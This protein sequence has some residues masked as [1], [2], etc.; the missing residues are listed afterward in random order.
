[1]NIKDVLDQMGK[2]VLSD[3]SKTMLSES[4]TEA[5]EKSVEDKVK[6]AVE[7]ALV[8]QDVLHAEKLENL[9]ERVDED[10]SSKLKMVLEKID[11]DHKG[12]LINIVEHYKGVIS[13]DAKEFKDKL[14]KNMSLFMETYLDD[15]IPADVI[16][17]AVENTKA[18]RIL[19]QVKELVAINDDYVT[20]VVQEAIQDGKATID[21]LKSE[22]GEIIKENMKLTQDKKFVEA[23]L[24]LENKSSNF[25]N[26]KQ[27]F[28][29]KTLKG[30]DLDYIEENFDYV[31]N[32]YDK[33][34]DEDVEEEKN[35][36]SSK[37][38]TEKIDTPSKVIEEGVDSDDS[39]GS[40]LEFMQKQDKN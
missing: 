35:N 16:Q 37:I 27:D 25:S 14:V 38:I 8:D 11:A 9:L 34:L 12:K 4:F 22:L 32:M 40:Y 3:E 33:K 13:E 24:L 17:E 6:L 15:M 23:S 31:S 7:S 21:T 19:E 28:V 30:K 29:K 18:R 39:V 26:G 5:V 20:D 36:T 1:M 10:H 2:D